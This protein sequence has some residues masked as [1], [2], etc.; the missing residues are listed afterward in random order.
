M[1]IRVFDPNVFDQ[2]P[3]F[4]TGG[5]GV[6]TDKTE[7]TEAWAVAGV[8]ITRVFDPDVFDL[9]P[10]FDTGTNAGRWTVRTKQ[11]ETWINI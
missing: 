9:N 11:S 3:I 4:D 1:T 7:Q 8:T 10:I 5:P 6:W 2:Y